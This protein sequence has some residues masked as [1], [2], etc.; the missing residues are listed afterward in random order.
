M[1]ENDEL[2]FAAL[3][4]ATGYL[5]IERLEDGCL[6]LIH[7]RNSHIGQW[8]SAENGFALLRDKSGQRYLAVEF[9]WDAS[10]AGTAKPFFKISDPISPASLRETLEA[11]LRELPYYVFAER[12]KAWL[13]DKIV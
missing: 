12:T 7:A 13:N 10:T 4:S 1:P 2:T 9:H 11:K 8:R 6:Y 3:Q 5:P